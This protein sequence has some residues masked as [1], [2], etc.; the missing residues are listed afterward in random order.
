MWFIYLLRDPRTALVRYVGQTTNINRRLITHLSKG[1][2][3]VRST[4]VADWI[5]EL[6]AEGLKPILDEMILVAET[7]E[8]ADR[9]ERDQIQRHAGAL[10]NLQSGGQSGYAVHETTREK[11]REMKL[12]KAQSPEHVRKRADAMR[13]HKVGVETRERIAASK[14]G[15]PRDAETRAKL[16]AAN[17]G[18]QPSEQ[19][20]AKLREAQ[21]L[22]RL[23]E[24]DLMDT[25]RKAGAA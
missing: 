8:Q 11:M 18:K 5:A 2:R 21:R 13:G 24:R 17:L 12:G 20:K 15:K 16:S 23:R 4:R 22:R 6:L 10:L 9:F 7:K 3:P 25:N 1:R 14:R 19:T